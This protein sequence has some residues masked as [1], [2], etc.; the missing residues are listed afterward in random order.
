MNI[1]KTV[2]LYDDTSSAPQSPTLSPRKD[3][4][5]KR[6]LEE[7][8]KYSNR[9]DFM[10]VDTDIEESEHKSSYQSKR[11]INVDSVSRYT[12][13]RPKKKRETTDIPPIHTNTTDITKSDHDSTPSP[14]EI[15]KTK[16]PNVLELLKASAIVV[17]EEKRAKY[18]TYYKL[19]SST[20]STNFTINRPGSPT[21]DCIGL[22][23]DK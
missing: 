11:N 12:T 18:L 23:S 7:Q 21:I 19:L 10:A 5:L 14:K 16:A 2:P 17:K 3:L 13:D 22:I 20:G 8:K 6:K 9:D 15:S 4:D 1:D